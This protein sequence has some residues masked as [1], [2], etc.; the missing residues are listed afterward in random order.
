MEERMGIK[1]QLPAITL[2]IGLI[3]IA[4]AL[5]H[6]DKIGVGLTLGVVALVAVRYVARRCADAY[7]VKIHP[8]HGDRMD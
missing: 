6:A 1:Y 2:A 4:L 5:L 8:E 3:T 7:L